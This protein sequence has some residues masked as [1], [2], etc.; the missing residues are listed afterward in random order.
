MH[1]FLRFM[2]PCEKRLH[3]PWDQLRRWRHKDAYIPVE[4]ALVMRAK[5]AGLL[6]RQVCHDPVEPPEI[7][8]GVWIKA[9]EHIVSLIG[10]FYLLYLFLRSDYRSSVNHALYLIQRKR[11]CFNGKRGMNRAYAIIPAQMRL[12]LKRMIAGYSSCLLRDLCHERKHGIRY[13]IRRYIAFHFVLPPS[14][15]GYYTMR[16]L[17]GQ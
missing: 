11:I 16:C 6:H 13:R 15:W 12:C 5:H 17:K 4:N 10:V 2:H 8:Q 14:V 9:A 7:L 3:L 1:V